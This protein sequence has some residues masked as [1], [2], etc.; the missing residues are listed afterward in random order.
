MLRGTG[1]G[2]GRR[3]TLGGSEGRERCQVGE[4]EIKGS[5]PPFSSQEETTEEHQVTQKE[6]LDD[7]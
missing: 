6:Q 5:R 7:F 3:V 1:K 2:T 4:G